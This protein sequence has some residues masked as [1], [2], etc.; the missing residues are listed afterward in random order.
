M[1]CN[2]EVRMKDQGGALLSWICL[3]YISSDLSFARACSLSTSL[4]L[5]STT[6]SNQLKGMTILFYVAKTPGRSLW[7]LPGSNW[8]KLLHIYIYTQTDTYTYTYAYTYTYTHNIHIR[9]RIRIRNIIHVII[10][11]YISISICVYRHSPWDRHRILIALV[12]RGSVIKERANLLENVW[13]RQ[14]GPENDFCM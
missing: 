2:D 13:F 7:Y 8:F 5:D 4:E 12:Q 1:I 9:I 10:Q 11:Y 3:L 6:K 14:A